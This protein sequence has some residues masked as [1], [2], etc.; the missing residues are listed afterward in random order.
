MGSTL[1]TTNIKELK[2]KLSRRALKSRITSKTILVIMIIILVSGG[3]IFVKAG[4]Y[5]Q[6]ELL[7]SYKDISSPLEDELRVLEAEYVGSENVRKT[8][9]NEAKVGLKRIGVNIEGLSE[10]EIVGKS[11]VNYPKIIKASN[12]SEEI[13]FNNAISRLRSASKPSGKNIN[14]REPYKNLQKALNENINK[15]K[16]MSKQSA[17][18]PITQLI[19]TNVTRF[20]ALALIFL[21][22]RILLSIYRFNV[23]LA[24]FYESRADALFLCEEDVLDVACFE[25]IVNCLAPSRE[26]NISDIGSADIPEMTKTLESFSKQ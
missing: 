19:S 4:E 11:H 17:P 23:R 13:H 12:E 1:K 20:G 25:K 7:L 5:S 21:F 26:I 10:E 3:Y 24:A 9:L 22:V 2:Y 15:R 18:A 8:I 14:F 16:E 6:I